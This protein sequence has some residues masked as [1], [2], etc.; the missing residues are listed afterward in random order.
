M[1]WTRA[2]GSALARARV[3]SKFRTTEQP[4]Q[5]IAARMWAK[6]S[7]VYGVINR[8]YAERLHIATTVRDVNVVHPT[9]GARRGAILLATLDPA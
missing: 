3:P 1:N 4:T 2:A 8:H 5:V 6:T 9:L 7:R